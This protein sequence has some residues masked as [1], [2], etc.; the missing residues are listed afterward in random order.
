MVDDTRVSDVGTRSAEA[1]SKIEYDDL[2]NPVQVVL[3]LE[4]LDAFEVETTGRTE[5]MKGS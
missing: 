1:L 5:A 4:S 3:P 2:D